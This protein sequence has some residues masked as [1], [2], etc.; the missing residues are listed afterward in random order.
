MLSLKLSRLFN[1][2]SSYIL[3]FIF[4]KK[5]FA[6]TLIKNKLSSLRKKN[7][8]LG[9]HSKLFISKNNNFLKP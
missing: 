2:L 9:Y 6:Q 1:D 7:I 4:N 8:D 3:F 5:S